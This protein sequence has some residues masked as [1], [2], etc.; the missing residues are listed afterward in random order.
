[1]GKKGEGPH[2]FEKGNEGKQSQ[3]GGEE[4][5]ICKDLT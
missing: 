5:R 2:W 4:K 1:M 3:G